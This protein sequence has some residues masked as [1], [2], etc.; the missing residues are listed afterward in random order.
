MR[1]HLRRIRND[2]GSEAVQI[3]LD[4]NEID[5]LEKIAQ[6]ERKR[7]GLEPYTDDEIQA[8][9]ASAR[10]NIRTI[11]Q[12]EVTY[13]VQF[14]TWDYQRGICKIVYELAWL[15]LGDAYL[16]D[17]VAEMLRTV[18]LSGTEQGI[19]GRITMG[20]DASPLSLW[21]GERKAHNRYAAGR[22]VFC[23]SASV[24]YGFWYH[25]SYEGSQ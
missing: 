12:P 1:Y 19:A 16:D 8:L 24:R 10:R 2:D 6:R 5:E 23:W 7:A 18:I 17:P 11:E 14:D 21:D 9:M 13:A 15:W 4:I 25:R 3:A 22:G 20:S